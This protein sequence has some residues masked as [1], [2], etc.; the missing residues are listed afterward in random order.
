V[1]TIL[2]LFLYSSVPLVSLQPFFFLAEDLLTLSFIIPI[3]MMATSTIPQS[4][5]R[6]EIER[7]LKSWEDA[8]I[9]CEDDDEV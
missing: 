4:K 1:L 5:K 9:D 2:L 8:Q 3:F 7:R 6:W